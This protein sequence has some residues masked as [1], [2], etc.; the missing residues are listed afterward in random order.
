[1]I[2]TLGAGYFGFVSPKSFWFQHGQEY[3]TI[4][5]ERK[6]EVDKAC[7]L[8]LDRKC[9]LYFGII[10]NID[11][12]LEFEK[13]SLLLEKYPVASYEDVKIF[14]PFICEEFYGVCF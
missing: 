4:L 8:Y 7:Y 9:M 14:F 11:H 2:S 1:M 12:R 10:V 6:A 13:K 3:E 5:I